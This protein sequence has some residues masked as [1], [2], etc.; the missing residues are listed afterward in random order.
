MAIKEVKLS[1]KQIDII[2]EKVQESFKQHST[3]KPTR[4]P[5]KTETDKSA[6]PTWFY[7]SSVFAAFIFTAYISIFAT[8]HFDNIEYMNITIVF[9]FTSMVSFFLISAIFLISEKKKQH[10]VAPIIFFVGIAAIMI[11]AFKAVDTSDLVRYSIIYTIIV[12]AI[13]MYVLA[14][15]R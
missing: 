3:N 7:I 13:S 6:V 10:S 11:Y 12:A 14:I 9:F 2:E 8:I 5:K 1:Q 4:Y 15:R